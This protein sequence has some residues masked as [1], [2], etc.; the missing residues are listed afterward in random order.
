[1]HPFRTGSRSLAER[2]FQILTTARN[3]AILPVSD[4]VAIEAARLRADKGLKAPDAI[5]IATARVGG[6]TTFVTNDT[7]LHSLS[8]VRVIVLEQLI[9]RN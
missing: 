6:A 4:I 9:A 7:G 1:M 3:L 5:Q 8:D 2:Y